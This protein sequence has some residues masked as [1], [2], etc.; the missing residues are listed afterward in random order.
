MGSINLV[1]LACDRYCNLSVD[2]NKNNVTTITGNS[3]R[4]GLSYARKECIVPSITVTTVITV[5]NGTSRIVPV[6]SE[7]VVPKTLIFDILKE[8]RDLKVNAPIKSGD[9]IKKNILNTGINIVAT[10]TVF[11]SK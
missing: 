7:I 4:N 1:C 9:I 10:G 3:C 2:L 11:L 8:L 6:K 5:T